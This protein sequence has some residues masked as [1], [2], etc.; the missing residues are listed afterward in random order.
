M[1]RVSFGSRAGGVHDYNN[2]SSVSTYRASQVNGVYATL[3]DLIRALTSEIEACAESEV[4]ELSTCELAIHEDTVSPAIIPLQRPAIGPYADGGQHDLPPEFKTE[5]LDGTEDFVGL[6][7]PLPKASIT[8]ILNAGDGQQRQ[9]VQR[10][11]S[12]AIVQCIEAIDGFKYSFNNAWN[13]KDEG[14]LRYS[15]ICQDSMQNKDRHANGFTKT[16]KHLKGEG[17]RGPR[18]PTYDCKGSVSIKFSSIRRRVDVY[19]RHYAIHSSVAERKG[20]PKPPGGHRV[21]HRSNMQHNHPPAGGAEPDTGRL[22]GHL[23]DQDTPYKALQPLA[24]FRTPSTQGGKSNKRKRDESTSD[25]TVKPLSLFEILQQSDTAKAPEVMPKTVPKPSAAPPPVE[26]NLPSWQAPAPAPA[27]VPHQ[28]SALNGGAQPYAP[29]APYPPPYQPLDYQ[30]GRGDA[31]PNGQVAIPRKSNNPLPN[32]SASHVYH[33]ASQGKHPQAQGLFSTLKPIRK[34]TYGEASRQFIVY[35][36]PGPPRAKTSCTNCRF[37]KK[38]V[39]SD[40]HSYTLVE[41]DTNGMVGGQCDEV[42]PVCGACVRGNKTG[43]VYEHTPVGP[44]AN[45]APAVPGAANT[46]IYPAA[47]SA[48]PS[49]PP[50]QQQQRQ[51]QAVRQSPLVAATIVPQSNATYAGMGGAATYPPPT[52]SAHATQAE[53]SSQHQQQQQRKP[54]SYHPNPPNHSYPTAASSQT[55]AASQTPLPQSRKL[56]SP[57]PWFPNR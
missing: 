5:W 1:A 19:Y 33:G 57:D 46:A 23:Q 50:Q 36:Q 54:Q 20:A 21:M 12:R 25:A 8:A 27:P 40:A 24:P 11:A 51:N 53:P 31:T 26:Y 16:Q 28:H 30:Y 49:A 38:K 7:T 29:A 32:T 2:G 48:T 9:I 15:Y 35:A 14:G 43:C 47:T 34:P 13:A 10:A 39:R 42:R 3:Q 41:T 45:Y 52:P 18:K 37:S 22:L 6:D 4:P 55:F 56:E 17:E 44:P